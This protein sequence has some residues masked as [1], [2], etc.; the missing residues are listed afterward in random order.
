VSG[1]PVVVAIVV[2]VALVV[3]LMLLVRCAPYAPGDPRVEDTQGEQ[4]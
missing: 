2:P 1:L 3:F 4:A